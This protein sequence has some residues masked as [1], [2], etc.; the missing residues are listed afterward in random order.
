MELRVGFN[1]MRHKS[2]LHSN[3]YYDYESIFGPI[4]QSPTSCV[5]D[6][7][8][9]L[10]ITTIW[11]TIVYHKD[12]LFE[13]HA[14]D[15]MFSTWKLWCGQFG[16]LFK[17]G[18]Q[19]HLMWCVGNISTG[20]RFSLKKGRKRKNWNYCTCKLILQSLFNIWNES[21]STLYNTTSLLNGKIN[22]SESAFRIFRMTLWYW[23]STLLR[24]ITSRSRT[25][26]SLCI[27][28]VWGDFP[29]LYSQFYEVIILKGTYAIGEG[30]LQ[31][32]SLNI[33]LCL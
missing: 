5:G 29:S 15:C 30:K 9:Y 19:H 22:N 23:W 18:K 4:D 32:V 6:H 25:R 11:E 2:K 17:W 7:A 12:P 21:C 28:I 10:G 24:I 1:H 26:C 20:R 16:P 3:S 14:Q 33:E 27:G 31:N 8:T 13:W